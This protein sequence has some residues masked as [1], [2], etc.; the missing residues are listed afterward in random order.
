MIQLFKPIYTLAI[1]PLSKLLRIVIGC[2]SFFREKTKTFLLLFDEY[3]G[4]IRQ[5]L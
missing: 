5:L 3:K 4:C 1:F 2:S